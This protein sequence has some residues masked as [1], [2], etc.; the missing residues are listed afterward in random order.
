[1]PHNF[2]LN[3]FLT[4]GTVAVEGSK[5]RYLVINRDPLDSLNENKCVFVATCSKEK[6][7]YYAVTSDSLGLDGNMVE[8]RYIIPGLNSITIGV[9][10]KVA[11]IE[12]ILQIDNLPL[13]IDNTL[14]YD[15]YTTFGGNVK[16]QYTPEMTNEGCLAFNLGIVPD[17]EPAGNNASCFFFYGGGGNAYE[18]VSSIHID[19]LWMISLE[20][21]LPNFAWDSIAGENTKW[22]GYNEN[23]DVYG[24]NKDTPPP[25]TG[26]VKGY[27]IHRLAWTRNWLVRAFPED[28]DSTRMMVHGTSNGCIG[29]L[30]LSYYYPE[31]ISS[32]D[33]VNSKVNAQYLNDDDPLC[34]WN[35]DGTSREHADIFLGTM[36]SNLPSDLPKINGDG[37]YSMWEW[38]NFNN[39][40]RDNKYRSL[41]FVYLTSGKEDYVTCW[42]EKIGY[43]N[44]INAYKA[45]GQYY[46]DLREHKAGHKS[47]K[48]NPFSSLTRF[49]TKTSYPAFSN[50][51]MNQNP[52]DTDNPNFPIMMA[53][54][55]GRLMEY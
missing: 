24:A 1:M 33:V 45:G 52:G 14:F 36:E 6:T 40:L 5:P 9:A 17:D 50:C 28:L 37:Y 42:E 13:L 43:Y 54:L 29:A 46:W 19:G 53:T 44:S 22:L 48:D 4:L 7:V 27:T 25:T 10:E 34:K 47:I 35:E 23:F 38:A 30:A 2:A 3:Y 55:L 20:D 11:P 26:I 49:N 21:V 39:L 8:N 15:A 18:N 41:P 31:W 16:T 32:C 51:S 12:A